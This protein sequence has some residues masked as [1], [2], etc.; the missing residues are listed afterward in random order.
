MRLRLVFAALTAALSFI[1]LKA[2]SQSVADFYR[3]KSIQL[4]ISYSAGGGYDIQS[5]NLARY[6]TKYVPGNPMIV[7]VNYPGAGGLRLAN[8]LYNAASKDGTVFGSLARNA[9]TA[10]LLESK[11][12]AFDPRRYTW[13]GS[14]SDE[15]SVCASWHTSKVKTFNDLMTNPFVAGAPGAISDAATY[16]KMI[17]NI[18]DANIKLVNGYPGTNEITIAMERGE[19]DGLCGWVLGNINAS[20]PDWIPQK[21]INVLMQLSTRRSPSLPNVPLILDL[22][23]NDKE[24]QIFALMFSRQQMAWPFAAPPDVPADRA[25]ALRQAFDATMRDPGFIAESKK[26][27]FSID[28]MKGVEMDALIKQLY[29]TPPDVIATAQGS[30]AD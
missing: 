20:R 27:S 16:T 13:I 11:G 6:M 17:K 14:I 7:P 15:V 28:P 19:V 23:R 5:R 18:F 3:G 1:P 26:Q 10:P 30:I 29:A 8:H 22:A 2:Q 21:K 9:S 25:A 24:R 4:M 12:I